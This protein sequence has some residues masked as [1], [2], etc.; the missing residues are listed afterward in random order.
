MIL[1][2]PNRDV[3]GEDEGVHSGEKNRASYQNLLR[4]LG[5][6]EESEERSLKLS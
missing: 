4:A 3:L 2:I 5:T 1:C 6:G